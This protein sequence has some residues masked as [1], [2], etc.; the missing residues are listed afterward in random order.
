[1]DTE[2]FEI[3]KYYPELYSASKTRSKLVKVPSLRT[4]AING[5]GDFDGPRYKESLAALQSVTFALK[6]LPKEGIMVDDY[7]NFNIT[8]LECLWSS[9]DGG[10]F[11]ASA[12]HN[13]LWELFYVVPGFVTPRLVNLAVIELAKK[14]SNP[15][16]HSV[17]VNTLQEKKC[18]QLLHVG[19]YDNIG[20]SY[21]K[22]MKYI[23]N[24]GLKPS[25]RYHEIY[26]NDPATTKKP[27]L[28][29]ILRQ[30]VVRLG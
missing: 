8:A 17:H 25:S 9:K 26:L 3:N 13:E 22:L 20:K 24:S 16:I 18:A 23:V 7:L 12:R 28:R 10:I 11:D 14:D 6:N 30:P 4:L 19:S 5:E 29:T 15:M 21:E 27:Y 2:K 1:M